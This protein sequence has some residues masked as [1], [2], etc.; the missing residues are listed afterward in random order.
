MSN[1][2]CARHVTAHF[3]RKYGKT[4]RNC[5]QID[6][7]GLPDSPGGP[8]DATYIWGCDQILV[9][10]LLLSQY[11]RYTILAYDTCAPYI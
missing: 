11:E 2:A 4:T 3:Y 10:V 5:T 9:A 1:V 6:P 8:R 7:L